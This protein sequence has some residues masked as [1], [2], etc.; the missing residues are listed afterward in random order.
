M[1]DAQLTG[2]FC[3]ESN[4]QVVIARYDEGVVV[5]TR[6]TGECA[7]VQPRDLQ[8]LIDRRFSQLGDRGKPLSIRAAAARSG[9][10]VSHETLRLLKAGRHSGSISRHTAEGL[11]QAL[12]VPLT[13]ILKLAGQRIPQG[14]F[15]LPQEADTLTSTEREAVLAVVNAI[16]HAGDRPAGDTRAVAS[17]G[18][19]PGGT[20]TGAKSAAKTARQARQQAQ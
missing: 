19:R 17:A 3:H 6:S 14:A 4:G 11:A 12:D 1:I 9:G 7:M 16:L 20:S 13:T 2:L 5:V 15:V 18:R 10:Q 8:E